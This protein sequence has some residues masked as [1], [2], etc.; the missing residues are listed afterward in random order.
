[1]TTHPVDD[2]LDHAAIFR[3]LWGINRSPPLLTCELENDS[4]SPLPP[5]RHALD[6][7]AQKRLC[8]QLRGLALEVGQ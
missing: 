2:K 6:E 7:Q 4:S 5:K 3:P 1:M 8:S